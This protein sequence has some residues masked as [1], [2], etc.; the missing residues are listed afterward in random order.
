MV[1]ENT[2]GTARYNMRGLVFKVAGKTAPLNLA[3]AS[4]TPGSQATP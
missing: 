3:V 1:T 4:L 2:R